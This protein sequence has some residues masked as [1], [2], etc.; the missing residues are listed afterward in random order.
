MHSLNNFYVCPMHP[1]IK[2]DRPG[3]CPL[4][5]MSLERKIPVQEEENSELKKMTRR[6]WIGLLFT[7]PILGLV[8]LDTF[9]REKI[10]SFLPFQISAWMQAIL[11]TPVVLW[12]GFFFFQRGWQGIA[13]LQLNMFSLI[14]LGVG[15]AYIYSLIGAF[16]PSLFPISFRQGGK[17]IGLYFEAAT[18]ITLLVI[19]GQILELKA[20]AKTSGAIKELMNLAPK[21]A[22]LISEN[23]TETTILLEEIKKGEVLRVK[24]GEKI[25]VD[26]VVIEG[27][28]VI[29]ESMITGESVPVEKQ[30]G[31]KVTGATLNET[32]SFLMRAEKIGSETLLARMIQ[33]VSEAQSSRVPIQKLVDR[34]TTY[35]VP[36]IVLIAIMTFFAWWFAGP[37]PALA[38]AIINAVSVL[39]IACPCALGLATPVSVMAGVGKGATMGI[40]I[41]DAEALEWMTKVDTVIFDK[42]G[43]LTEGKIHLNHIFSLEAGKEEAILQLSAS[44]ESLSE[45]PLSSAI[46]SLA[47]EKRLPLLQT[48][49]FHSFTGMGI[50]G[51]VEGKKIAIGNQ[52]LMDDQ[53]IALDSLTKQAE[54]AQQ[55]GQTVLYFAQDGHAIGWLAVSDVLKESTPEAVRMLHKENIYLVMLT[56]DQYSTAHAIGKKLK[57]DQIESNVLP[58]D[59][60][61]IV[62]ELQSRSHI[63]A[64]AGDGINDAPA[65]ATAHVGIAM[66]TGTDVAMESA[67]VTLVKG[68]LRGIA[69]ARNLSLATFRNIRQN[70]AWAFVYNILGVPIAAGVLYPFGLLLSPM[71]AS[72]AM[73]FS[74]VSVIWNALR[75]RRI[76]L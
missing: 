72:A 65:L 76:K 40:L 32:G 49:D 53:S 20:R 66:G 75:L 37:S 10:E 6:F 51:K 38:Y 44:L 57:I 27:K 41:K 4:C 22:T 61:K 2:Q 50:V 71:I 36:S 58:Q 54:S 30:Q 46:V 42:T 29:D 7:L 52:K 23:G 25:P 28:S 33:M 9:W 64:M 19:I 69:R 1:E 11:A 63:V 60:S 31:D 59:K 43:T 26:G 55:A 8:L 74:S 39:I 21:V 73:A 35:F 34:V 14:A 67:G 12:C 5:G 16:F 70:L 17:W 68:D 56:G 18:V 47:N 13:S 62:K 48:E 15:A 3:S 45:H 24:P